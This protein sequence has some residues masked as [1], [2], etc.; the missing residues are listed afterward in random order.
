MESGGDLLAG[1]DSLLHAIDK[2]DAGI[3]RWQ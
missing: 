1:V 2:L 3:H